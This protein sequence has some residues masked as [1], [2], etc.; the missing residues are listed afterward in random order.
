MAVAAFLRVIN[1]LENIRAT[2]DI[3]ENSQ[4]GLFGSVA[5]DL[6]L[7]VEETNDAIG[8]LAGAGLHPEA[9]QLLHDA[10]GLVER[11]AENPRANL[12]DQAIAVLASARTELVA[13]N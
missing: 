9:V 7:A 8:V 3:L 12:V 11:A 2:V 5:A 4:Y 13:S 6:R 10:R 1:A